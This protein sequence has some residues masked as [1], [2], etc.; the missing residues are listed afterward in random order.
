[1][2]GIQMM[3]HTPLE[4]RLTNSRGLRASITALLEFDPT[5]FDNI[6]FPRRIDH[7]TVVDTILLKYANAPLAHPDPSYMKYYMGTWARIRY[8]VWEEWLDT[9]EYEYN[10]IHNYDRTATITDNVKRDQT[11]QQSS[12]ANQSATATGTQD[13]TGSQSS[14][15][16]ASSDT[17][18]HTSDSGST[19]IEQSSNTKKQNE[20][21]V[22]AFNS[23]AYQ[24]DNKDSG[25][26]SQTGDQ[27][28]T[29]SATSDSNTNTK[30]SASSEA[31][32]TDTV[33]TSSDSS[34]SSSQNAT[35]S[36]SETESHTHTELIQGNIGVT[37][38][39]QMIES[40]RNIVDFSLYTIIADEW[41]DQFC[42]KV[43]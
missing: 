8:P 34:S 26:E 35:S 19:D 42:L 6:Q 21:S 17:T 4:N 37:T 29:V 32:S 41:Y 38:T 43:W 10:P 40:Q 23:S 15:S 2:E 27:S 25:T 14:Q 36:E 16:N 39:Q 13:A 20:H 22:S 28:T 9:L 7:D 3:F 33:N 18:G 31:M 5:I 1:M 11:G 12:S 30:D 24:P